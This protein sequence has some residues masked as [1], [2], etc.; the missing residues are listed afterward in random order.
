MLSEIFS[1]DFL[2]DPVPSPK[3][4]YLP[5]IIVFGLLI[6]SA[7]LIMIFSRQD[8]RK[9]FGKYVPVLLSTGVLGYV[10]LF[11]RYEGLPWLAARGFFGAVALLFIVWVA[12]LAAWTIRYLPKYKQE[13]KVEDRFKKYLP[14]EK[15]KA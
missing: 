8:K 1:N 7:I 3:M 12:I 13:K 10:H 11:A 6:L 5:F 9:I 4:F 15:T 14:K 2:F